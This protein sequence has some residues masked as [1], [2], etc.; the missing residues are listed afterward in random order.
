MTMRGSAIYI[1]RG[2]LPAQTTE[3]PSQELGKLREIYRVTVPRGEVW[4]IDKT[5]PFICYLTTTELVNFL[6]TTEEGT[7]ASN[8]ITRVLNASDGHV[9]SRYVGVWADADG[10]RQTVV[11][12]WDHVDG[13]GPGRV[14]ISP[15]GVDLPSR[16]AYV[17]YE[18]AH[19]VLSIDA[20]VGLGERSHPIFEADGKM[21]FSSNQWLHQRIGSPVLLPPDF[22]IVLKLN[23]QWPVAFDNGT[24]PASDITFNQIRIPIIA[25]QAR[26]FNVPGERRAGDTLRAMAER[27]MVEAVR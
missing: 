3:T 2:S 18:D 27:I 16:V 20:P 11:D 8:Q 19:I 5:R 22:S 25:Y 17:P 6:A 23:A 4:G 7:L 14:T 15:I 9:D 1:D 24:I 12:V 13:P 10:A 26:D 21:L